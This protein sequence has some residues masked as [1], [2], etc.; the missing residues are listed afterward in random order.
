MRTLTGLW[1]WR[2]NPLRRT[3]DL[4]E[5]WAALAAALLLTVAVPAF[6]FLCGGLAD[7]ALRE[8]ARAQRAERHPTTA[9]VLRQAPKAQQAVADPEAGMESRSSRMVVA[10]WTAADGTRH[11]GTV[12][13]GVR[14]ANPGATFRIWTD[15][16]GNSVTRPMNTDTAR[17]HAVLAGLGAAAVAAGA[18]EGGRRLF[19]RRLIQRRY[20]Q[21]DRAWAK[22]GPDWGRTGT[23]S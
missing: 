6:G 16:R 7:A 14:K 18:V 13:A 5:A 19:V 21:L 15:A 4:V 9:R 3:T 1:R 22:T 12:A 20:V 11:T 17:A 2:H 8:S 23:G 10:E